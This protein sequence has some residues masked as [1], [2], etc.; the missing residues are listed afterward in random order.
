MSLIDYLRNWGESL[1]TSKKAYI[2]QQAAIGSED[3]Q[4]TITQSGQEI[5]A[6]CDG[7]A[8]INM[9]PISATRNSFLSAI[10]ERLA[11]QHEATVVGYSARLHIPVKKG[12]K[13][14]ILYIGFE[15]TTS[16]VCRFFS[17]V[18]G[19]LR[20]FFKRLEVAYVI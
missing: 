18:G 9:T 14:Q 17:L 19:G 20:L 3:S 5:V 4:V 15:Q 10:S 16:A 6:P 7:Y 12:E 13:V 8:F 1:F 2:S 11:H